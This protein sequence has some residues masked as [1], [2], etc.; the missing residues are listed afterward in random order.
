MNCFV[1]VVYITHL[2]FSD[3]VGEGAMDETMN[4]PFTQPNAN[5]ETL[6]DGILHLL[7]LFKEPSVSILLIALL[8]EL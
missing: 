1:V 6:K 4:Q 3:Q 5:T 2:F 7:H 8:E